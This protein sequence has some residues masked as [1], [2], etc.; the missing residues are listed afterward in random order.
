MGLDQ[1]FQ[2]RDSAEGDEQNP[3]VL[4]E[5]TFRKHWEL[6][7]WIMKYVEGGDPI[8]FNGIV[9]FDQPTLVNFYHSFRN[10]S[11]IH[12]MCSELFEEDE[13]GVV[14]ISFLTYPKYPLESTLYYL[15]SC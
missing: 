6:H 3:N 11:R 12:S 15:Y 13:E 5:W 8:S 4:M 1:T 7:E 9:I 14:S 2:L 10:D